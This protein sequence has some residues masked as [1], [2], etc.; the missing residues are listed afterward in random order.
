MRLD[1]IR[2]WVGATLAEDL[3]LMRDMLSE[4]ASLADSLHPEFDDPF[5]QRRFPVATLLFAVAGP[6]QQTIHWRQVERKINFDMVKLLVEFGADVN[7][8]SIHGLP[9]CWARERRIASYLIEHGAEINRWHHNGGSPL[10]FSVWQ[11]DPERMRMLLELGA[12]PNLPDPDTGEAALHIA[13]LRLLTECVRGLLEFGA[14]PNS[15]TQVGVRSNG[16]HRPLLQGETTLHFAAELGDQDM[17]TALV[18]AGADKSAVNALGETPR[19]FAAKCNR[20][21]NIVNL[22]T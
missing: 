9:L 5:R 16:A 2:Q 3:D 1:P 10:F 14:N 7:I 19:D 8:V 12:D 11:S 13:A 20:G 21:E 18:D 6:P 22:L 17:I 4:D 15:Q